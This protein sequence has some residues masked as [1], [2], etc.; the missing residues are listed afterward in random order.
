MT[1][2]D[3][4]QIRNSVLGVFAVIFGLLIWFLNTNY[5]LKKDY[6]D[7]KKTSFRAV[8]SSKK[9]EH[10]TKGNKI[11]LE[12]GPMLIV[13]RELFDKLH[14]GDSI[15]KIAN[16]DSIYFYTTNGIIIDDYNE[17]KR[18]KYLKTLK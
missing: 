9:D 16:S 6:L 1:K 18:E 7:F 3:D 11:Y 17:F 2:I 8:L 14:I 15:I 5:F 4:K 13:H 10:P 12:N